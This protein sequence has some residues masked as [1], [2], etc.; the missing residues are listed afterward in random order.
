MRLQ[1]V[2]E[3]FLPRNCSDGREV[4]EKGS[5]SKIFRRLQ[6]RM[7]VEIFDYSKL[8]GRT[9]AEIAGAAGKL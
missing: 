5:C 8:Q 2:A 6:G 3:G 4:A 9:P 7:A 1:E